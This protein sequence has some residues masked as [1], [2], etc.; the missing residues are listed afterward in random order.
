M[1]RVG[2]VAVGAIV[3]LA[4]L[5]SINYAIYFYSG[6]PF[7]P[8][9]S[10]FWTAARLA[11]VD[12]SRLYDAELV[13]QA[14]SWLVDPARGLRPWAYPPSGLL[15]FL[16]FSW[17][18][19]WIS[20][21]AW[22]GVSVAAYLW[23]ARRFASG[24]WLALVV[25]SPPFI[26]AAVSG[27]SALLVAAAILWAVSVSR[28]RPF[29]AG[30]VLGLAAAVK[31][32]SL[33]AAPLLLDRK[34]LTGFACGGSLAVLGSLVFG[35]G[36]WLIWLE[37]LPEFARIAT[38]MGLV[39]STPTGLANLLGA[40]RALFWAAGAALGVWLALSTRS[41]DAQARLVGLVGGGLLITPYAMIYDM[42]ALMPVAVLALAS[43]QRPSDL[44]RSLPVV[45]S[46]GMLT[47]PAMAAATILRK[48]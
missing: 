29:A 25:L 13:T 26:V 43:A 18:P 46:G 4:L 7:R 31:P 12:P 45:G 22:V 37:A 3:A 44:L 36:P 39:F 27:Q 11:L 9:Y 28:D 41:G 8:D 16:P 20:Y 21:F 2:K 1:G 5:S 48:R 10:V 34:G 17:L 6:N 38:D 42:V 24:W 19:F 33:V 15:A 47:V 32:Q 14:Q 40:P 35:I 23:A 30:L